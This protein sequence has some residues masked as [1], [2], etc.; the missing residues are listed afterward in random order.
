MQSFSAPSNASLLVC[1]FV[2]ACVCLCDSVC[3]LPVMPLWG[4]LSKKYYSKSTQ[5]CIYK[6]V[7]GVNWGSNCP[8]LA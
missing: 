4:F 7:L 8:C 5:L 6:W 3:M 2:C 1:V